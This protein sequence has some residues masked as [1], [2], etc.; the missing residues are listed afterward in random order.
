VHLN[1]GTELTASPDLLGLHPKLRNNCRRQPVVMEVIVSY[2]A[3][4]SPVACMVANYAP[5]NVGTPKILSLSHAA[6]SFIVSP[7]A[8]LPI[9]TIIPTLSP[10]P[11]VPTTSLFSASRVT[12]YFRGYTRSFLSFLQVILAVPVTTQFDSASCMT[13]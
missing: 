4:I 12:S 10:V 6:T 8:A 13:A 7:Y 5:S 1:T 9:L 11:T 2:C 3:C